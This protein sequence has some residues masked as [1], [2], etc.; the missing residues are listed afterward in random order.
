MEAGYGEKGLDESF[1]RSLNFI[2]KQK[3]RKSPLTSVKLTLAS[4]HF[5][6]DTRAF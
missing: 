6:G 5:R 3:K 4:T 1:I 2:R